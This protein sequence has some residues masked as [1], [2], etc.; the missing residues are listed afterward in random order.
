M[1][2]IYDPSWQVASGDESSEGASQAQRDVRV[3]E[4]FYPRPTTIP[5]RLFLTLHFMLL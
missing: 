4:A 3:L 5:A 2:F 1:Q